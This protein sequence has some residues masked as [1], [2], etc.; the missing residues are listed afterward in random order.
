MANPHPSPNEVPLPLEPPPHGATPTGED[1]VGHGVAV[2]PPAV[3]LAV[4]WL[5]IGLLQVQGVLAVGG[6]LVEGQTVLGVGH[7]LKQTAASAD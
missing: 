2:A 7:E 3:V 1:D 5:L 4:E 6:G